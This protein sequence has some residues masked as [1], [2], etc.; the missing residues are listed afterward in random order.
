MATVTAVV[1]TYNRAELLQECLDAVAAQT[2]PVDAAV[3]VDN[4]ST[5]GTADVLAARREPLRVLT[6]RSNTGGAG[7]FAAGVRAAVEGGSNAV[8]L[9]DDDTIPE[10]DALAELLRAHDGYPGPRPTLL[11]S[12]VVWTDGRDHPMNTPRT[13]P[14]ASRRALDAAATVGA[15]PVRSASFVSV[16]I[17][18]TAVAERGLPVADYFLWNDD[19]EYTARLLRGNVG[20]YVPTSVVVHKTKAFGSTDVDPG[21]R[22]Y[23]EVRNKIWVFTRSDALSSLEKVVYGGSTLNR[24]AHTFVDSDRPGVL[25]AGLRRGVRDARRPPRPTAE[26]LAAGGPRQGPA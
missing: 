15:R 1:V 7:G 23:F 25:W 17:D 9:L 10:P 8:W 11:A 24:W 4:A 22:F 13:L 18:A 3:V 2:R 19:F 21:E 26:V 6:M 5:D 14:A 12:R 20:L 16:L